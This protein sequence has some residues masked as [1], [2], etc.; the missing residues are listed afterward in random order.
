MTETTLWIIKSYQISQEA[1]EEILLNNLIQVSLNRSW[2]LESVS[3]TVISNG[4][5]TY[6][7]TKLILD[8]SPSLAHFMKLYIA[9]ADKLLPWNS[10]PKDIKTCTEPILTI[11]QMITDE[12]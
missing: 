12:E 5:C 7:F 4:K 8:C 1:E 10:I 9:S 6:Q 3:C 2:Q 11:G